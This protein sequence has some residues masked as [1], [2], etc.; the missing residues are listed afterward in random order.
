LLVAAAALGL[1]ACEVDEGPSGPE[2]PAG[3]EGESG[4]NGV[5][6]VDGTDG[7]DG[8]DGADGVNGADGLHCWDANG[9]GIEDFDEDTNAD[10]IWDAADCQ[11]SITREVVTGETA[12]S[13]IFQQSLTLTCGAGMVPYGG[14]YRLVAANNSTNVDAIVTVS[15]P[16]ADGWELHA[17][18]DNAGTPTYAWRIEG[19]VVCGN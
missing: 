10:S 16:T 4:T 18:G 9:D 11:P 14:G 17:H 5:D 13:T 1:A 8:S 19:S 12:T 3:E 7:V 15:R 6:G 2:G